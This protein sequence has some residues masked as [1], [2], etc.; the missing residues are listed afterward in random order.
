MNERQVLNDA[1]EALRKAAGLTAH[2]QREVPAGHRR[3]DA[4]VE[5][6]GP[7][8]YRFAVEVKT[9]D[10][11]Q[12]PA[13]VKARLAHTRLPPLLV[14]PYI[15]R[16]TAELCR[17][18]HLPFIDTAGNAYLEGP[19]LF[20]Y[21]T[22][23]PRPATIKEARFRALNP[24]GLRV[25]FALL[26]RPELARA[27]YRQIAAAAGVALGT[28]GPVFKDLEARAILR[29]ATGRVRT[30]LDPRQ[31]LD[32][33]TTH[34]PIALRPKLN[35]RRFQA[36]PERLLKADLGKGTWWG[37]EVAAARLTGHLKP[38][39]FTIYTR[40]P[41]AKL[42]TRNRMR[43]DG[44]GN[45]EILEALWTFPVA[46]DHPDLAPTVLTYADLLATKEGRNVEAARLVYE[47]W[48]EPTFRKTK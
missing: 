35:P 7:R 30:L 27:T 17:N 33:W 10:R 13:A 46:G 37:G 20:V 12:T 47:Q 16:E 45:V 15:T 4:I 8:K 2:V 42:V 40:E 3:L 24:A 21:V 39:F 34:Y 44:Q 11:F 19:G 18:L 26:C 29:A 48:I 43:A 5:I 6:D 22:G 28:V 32:E 23:H 9:V 31:L 36:D 41:L 1:M 14:A 38:A 25:I